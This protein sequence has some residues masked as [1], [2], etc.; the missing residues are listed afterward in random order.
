MIKYEK[1]TE[2]RK[3]FS[4]E[5][6]NVKIVIPNSARLNMGSLKIDLVNGHGASVRSLNVKDEMASFDLPSANAFRIRLSGKT[7]SGNPFQRMSSEEIKPQEAIIR[8]QIHQSL[9][10]IKRGSRSSFRAAIDYTGS[11]SKSFSISV[12][13][14]PTNVVV[15]TRGSVSARPGR[16]A[17]V[18]VY[19]TAPSSTPV[20]KV[21]KVHIFATSGS[22]KL[23]LVAHVMVVWSL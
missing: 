2:S 6:A 10:T 8:T 5:K 12:S 7:H 13:A 21:V 11:S 19:V 3:P 20:G 17:Y 22:I 14:S 16:S 18:P 23:S 4:G 1:W 15:S 9:L